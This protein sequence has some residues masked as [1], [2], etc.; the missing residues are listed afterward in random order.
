[1]SCP[2]YKQELENIKQE[3]HQAKK[4]LVVSQA[5]HQDYQQEIQRLEKI[6]ETK[7]ED[8]KTKIH[9]LEDGNISLKEEMLFLKD[10]VVVKSQELEELMA[11]LKVTESHQD[12]ECVKA[13]TEKADLVN[14][15]SDLKQHII[16][17]TEKLDDGKL[18]MQNCEKQNAEL[19][20]TI[21]VSCSET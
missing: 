1:M 14:E 17:M 11:K 9:H 18:V 12:I 13:V 8:Y 16:V 3:L 21:Q 20:K 7:S 19:V 15:I 4:Q 5:L 6:I 10:E 2:N